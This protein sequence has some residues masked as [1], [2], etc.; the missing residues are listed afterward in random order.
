MVHLIKFNFFH[1]TQGKK[2]LDTYYQHYHTIL[3]V[4]EQTQAYMFLNKHRL[5]FADD[6]GLIQ[7]QINTIATALTMIPSAADRI[8][9]YGTLL[10]VLW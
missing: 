6:P 8:L 10:D 1:L 2:P 9:T 3:H 4:L 7:E 5:Q